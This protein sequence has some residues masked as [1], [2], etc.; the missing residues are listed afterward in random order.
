MSCAIVE[1]GASATRDGDERKA[2]VVFHLRAGMPDGA[3]AAGDPVFSFGV[4]CLTACCVVQQ[5]DSGTGLLFSRGFSVVYLRG[6]WGWFFSS[7]RCFVGAWAAAGSRLALSFCPCT[8]PRSG[9]FLG[10]AWSFGVFPSGRVRFR[11]KDSNPGR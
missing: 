8:T 3:Q 11:Q 4:S 1:P 9:C 10:P 5:Y 6:A 2:L 7:R